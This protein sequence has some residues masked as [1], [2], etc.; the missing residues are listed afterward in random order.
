MRFSEM[1][2]APD[3]LWL[4]D[5]RGRYCAE[6]R[7]SYVGDRVPAVMPQQNQTVIEKIEV[8]TIAL[9]I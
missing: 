6:F 1:R 5:D 2:P 3:E 7:T 4:V 9:Q 8:C